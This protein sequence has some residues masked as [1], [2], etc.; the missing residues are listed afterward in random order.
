V[1]VSSAE[2][3][4]LMAQARQRAEI[5]LV[6]SVQESKSQAFNVTARVPGSDP[7]LAPLV[8]TTPRSGWW[9]CASE[10]GGGLACW[11]ETMRALEAAQ[12]ARDCLFAA[13]SGHEIGFLGIDAFLM[14]R[15]DLVKGARAWIYFGG[16]IGA[17]RQPNLVQVSDA[18][19]GRWIAAAL[20]QAGLA[21]DNEAEAGLV[22]RGEAGTLH[23][24][25]ARY[26]TLASG[27]EVFHN[28]A[29]RWPDAVD[30]ANLARYARALANGACGLARQGG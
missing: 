5:G 18:S 24:G 19:M 29:D 22:P 26:V 3:E 6:V 27:T 21:V 8:V 16:N 10:R 15:A 17:P 9:Q 20:E 30:V 23:R 4:W 2:A 28:P 12:P 14:P 25:G 11:L 7:G 1:Q 13:F